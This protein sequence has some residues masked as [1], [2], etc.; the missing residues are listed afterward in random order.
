MIRTAPRKEIRFGSVLVSKG[1][2][3]VEFSFEWDDPHDLA[4]SV[5]DR[6]DDGM[7]DEEHE[8]VSGLVADYLAENHCEFRR[9][10]VLSEDDFGRLMEAIDRVEEELLEGEKDFSNVFD[11]YV[12]DLAESVKESRAEGTE[13]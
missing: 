4:A 7:S 11:G 12:A 6:L 1:Q 10:R 2:A 5:D 13:P 9:H 8:W 3:D